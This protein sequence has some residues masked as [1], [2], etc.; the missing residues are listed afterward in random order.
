MNKKIQNKKHI[1]LY[2]SNAENIAQIIFY[3]SKE[4]DNKNYLLVIIM[5]CIQKKEKNKSVM[6]TKKSIMIFNGIFLKEFIHDAKEKNPL[7]IEIID[8]RKY[9]KMK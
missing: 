5:D 2:I 4:K 1:F 7:I 9:I 3:I 6:F 8:H